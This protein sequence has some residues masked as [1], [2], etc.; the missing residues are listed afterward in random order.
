MKSLYFSLVF[1]AHRF[2]WS[3]QPSRPGACTRFMQSLFQGDQRLHSLLQVGLY[4]HNFLPLL[5]CFLLQ[6]SALAPRCILW[7]S[8]CSA[9]GS[10]GALT[11]SDSIIFIIFDQRIIHI[12]SSYSCLR[13][14]WQQPFSFL[15]PWGT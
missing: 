2:L 1:K 9:F 5:C 15:G 11:V 14:S 13:V 10:S 4:L 8:E 6:E 3:T 7:V 12:S